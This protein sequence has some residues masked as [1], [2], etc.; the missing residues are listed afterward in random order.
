MGRLPRSHLHR[1][2]KGESK[3]PQTPNPTNLISG[4]EYRAAIFV[5]CCSY[6]HQAK[7]GAVSR[8][9][10]SAPPDNSRTE[11]GRK[12]PTHITSLPCHI[13]SVSLFL[14]GG[15]HSALFAHRSGTRGKEG[16]RAG[17]G[18]PRAAPHN[19]LIWPQ[20]PAVA[21]AP[22]S[23]Q[24]GTPRSS[25]VSS[26]S[27]GTAYEQRLKQRTNNVRTRTNNECELARTTREPRARTHPRTI[28]CV[29]GE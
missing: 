3:K 22:R 5:A 12:S 19:F 21:V 15:A 16:R 7:V 25:Q 4:C 24:T 9:R 14:L 18:K 23:E 28:S 2:M 17:A 10:E 26:H 1:L 13:C 29:C 11:Q 20:Q 8:T 27:D 6:L